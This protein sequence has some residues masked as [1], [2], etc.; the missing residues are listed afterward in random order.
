MG[1]PGQASVSQ[2]SQRIRVGRG[3]GAS[4]PP[5]PPPTPARWADGAAARRGPW[6]RQRSLD[7]HARSS[8]HFT[9]LGRSGKVPELQLMAEAF[10]QIHTP[11]PGLMAAGRVILDLVLL[12]SI[13]LRSHTH[14]LRPWQSLRVDLQSLLSERNPLDDRVRAS[15]GFRM[16]TTPSERSIP[17]QTRE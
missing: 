5:P 8:T 7:T 15:F 10:F 2:S 14:L 17:V 3:R 6:K 9:S 16:N 12:Q 13:G 11:A 1:N 4:P